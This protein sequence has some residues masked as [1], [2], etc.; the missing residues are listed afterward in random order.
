[1]KPSR[2]TG[3][4]KCPSNFLLLKHF[5]SSKEL[6]KNIFN[7]IK[8]STQLL[9]STSNSD[10]VRKRGDNYICLFQK[11]VFFEQIREMVNCDGI[12]QLEANL[13]CYSYAGG[14]NS[15]FG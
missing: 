14:Q 6:E 10:V 13:G 15:Y 5:V 12:V 11:E 8:M 1:M 9:I 4:E 2:Q 7:T 3:I